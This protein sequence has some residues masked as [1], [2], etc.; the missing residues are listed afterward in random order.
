MQTPPKVLIEASWTYLAASE[1][2]ETLVGVA[3]EWQTE[4]RVVAAQSVSLRAELSR[5][6]D[7]GDFVDGKVLRIDIALKLGLKWSTDLTET[8]PVDAVEEGVI[9]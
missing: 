5:V 1:S 3:N 8:V 2:V 7:L 9:L 6:V 4:C